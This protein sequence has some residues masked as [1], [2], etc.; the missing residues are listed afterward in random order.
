[1][2]FIVAGFLGVEAFLLLALCSAYVL[3]NKEVPLVGR[4]RN[5]DAWWR[6]A[7]MVILWPI[8]LSVLS[9][10]LLLK[11][12]DEQSQKRRRDQKQ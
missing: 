9:V 8:T 7:F 6:V 4:Q 3:S 1:M 5:I 10:A 11:Y 2:E 12:D